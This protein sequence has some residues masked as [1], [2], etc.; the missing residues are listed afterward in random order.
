MPNIIT[1]FI[2]QNGADSFAFCMPTPID[3]E[4]QWFPARHGLF[5]CAKKRTGSPFCLILKF[6][7]V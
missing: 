7:F 2:V 1:F 4:F 6:N 3:P 5:T